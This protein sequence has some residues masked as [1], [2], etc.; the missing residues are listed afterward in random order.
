[1]PEESNP[2]QNVSSFIEYLKKTKDPAVV[3]LRRILKKKEEAGKDF[4]MKSHYLQEFSRSAKNST[5]IFDEN[6]QRILELEKQI[7]DQKEN[8][9]DHLKKAETAIQ[10]AFKEGYK[11][12]VEKGEKTGFENATKEY[13]RQMEAIENRLLSIL[14]NIEDSRKELLLNSHKFLLELVVA[15]AQKVINTEI[16]VNKEIIL[17]VIKKALSFIVS[18]QDLILRVSPNDIETVISKKKHWASIAEHLDTISIKEDERISQGGCIIESNSGI[19]DARLDIQLKEIVNTIETAWHDVQSLEG[20]IEP[21]PAY[22]S[23]DIIPDS[24][25]NINIS[26]LGK[27]EET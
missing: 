25:E 20:Q 21:G 17:S 23:K 10:K 2:P 8:L 13:N 12:G 22:Q 9:A 1:M 16:S 15:I 14:K 6:E 4:P 5:V 26:E 19:A 27:A 11:K 24:D 18:R 7:L 3:G